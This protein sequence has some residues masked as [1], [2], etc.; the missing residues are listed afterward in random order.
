MKRTLI[1]ALPLLSL[2]ASPVMA[3]PTVQQQLAAVKAKV[4]ELQS[5]LKKAKIGSRGAASQGRCHDRGDG[6]TSRPA[7]GSS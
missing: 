2:S 1:T 3:G 6:A 4:A 7:G 5:Q